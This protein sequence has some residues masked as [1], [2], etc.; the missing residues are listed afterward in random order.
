MKLLLER[1]VS[2]EEKFVI[3]SSR[4]EISAPM[5]DL[6]RS[7]PYKSI[8]QMIDFDSRIQNQNDPELRAAY[9]NYCFKRTE[10]SVKLSDAVNSMLVSTASPQV[11]CHFNIQGRRS[12]MR[13]PI[14]I[15]ECI[16]HVILHSKNL[17]RQLG[18]VSALGYVGSIL[19]R[20]PRRAN[21]LSKGSVR[22]NGSEIDEEAACNEN[23]ATDNGNVC[24]HYDDIDNEDDDD[25]D[26]EDADGDVEDDDSDDDDMDDAD[27]GDDVE[28]VNNDGVNLDNDSIM[29]E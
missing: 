26:V 6:L 17:R 25:V 11:L 28:S 3:S 19:K 5:T 23:A 13:L 1:M 15:S 10:N 9:L 14:A 20:M 8:D 16:V 7:L 21:T 2:L 24:D 27:V 12:K 4:Q 29:E 18:S 22:D